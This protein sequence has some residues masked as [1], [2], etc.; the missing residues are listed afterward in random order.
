MAEL[1][2]GTA[3]GTLVHAVFE[4]ADLTA[5]DLTAELTARCAEQLHPQ[6]P[7]RRRRPTRWPKRWRPSARTPL[8]PLAD[9]LRLA[10]IAPADRLA[11][12]DFELPLGGGDQPS[13]H[14]RAARRDRPAA[15]GHLP[16]DDPLARYPDLLADPALADQPLRGYLT[17]S[18]DAVLR[19]PG[20]RFAVVDYK[21]NWL[22]PLAASRSPR[23]TT[24]PSASPPR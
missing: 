18:I 23:R 17:G 10:D 12:L 15:A 19:L 13:R 11:E 2:T 24:P 7:A 9:G 22:G 3:F 20:P 5:P 16:A 8:G 1:P 14:H 4:V 21:T 6:P